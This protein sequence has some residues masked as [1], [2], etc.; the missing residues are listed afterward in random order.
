MGK[1][2]YSSK[3][4]FVMLKPDCCGDG[5]CSGDDVWYWMELV[6]ATNVRQSRVT[7]FYLSRLVGDRAAGIKCARKAPPTWGSSSVRR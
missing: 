6:S 4:K 7:K 3:Q 5:L 2:Y 1:F